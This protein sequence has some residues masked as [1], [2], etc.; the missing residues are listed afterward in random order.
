M[1]VK[2]PNISSRTFFHKLYSQNALIS[3][4]DDD[5]KN[6]LSGIIAK[7]LKFKQRLLSQKPPLVI[8]DLPVNQIVCY[9]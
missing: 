9:S 2:S 7:E 4:N 5:A 6:A 1:F 8:K 3:K